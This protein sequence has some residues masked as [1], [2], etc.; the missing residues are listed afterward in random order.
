MKLGGIHLSVQVPPA[1]TRCRSR[2]IIITPWQ[3]PILDAWVWLITT[4]TKTSRGQ[5]RMHMHAGERHDVSGEDGANYYSVPHAVHM[6]G[7]PHNS[8]PERAA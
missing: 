6:P 2:G 4:V 8:S 3:A 5:L 7:S 1:G